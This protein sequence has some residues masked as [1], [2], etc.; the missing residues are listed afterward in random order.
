[1]LYQKCLVFL[2]IR[3]INVDPPLLLLLGLFLIT[4]SLVAN[5]FLGAAG[6]NTAIADVVLFY[7]FVLV[8]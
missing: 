2:G 4:L 7:F 8:N 1:M 6:A 3:G 5:Q